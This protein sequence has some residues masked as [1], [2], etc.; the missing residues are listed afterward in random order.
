MKMHAPRNHSLLHGNRTVNT[1][2]VPGVKC[3]CVDPVTP[4]IQVEEEVEIEAFMYIVVVIVF[5]AT[6]I[7]FLLIKYARNDDEEK[8]LKY[9]YSEFVKRERFQAPQY[10]NKL[11]LERTKMCLE[12]IKCNGVPGYIERCPMITITTC[13]EGSES[14]SSGD[15]GL[16]ENG[17]D[18]DTDT[19][20]NDLDKDLA[21]ENPELSLRDQIDKGSLWEPASAD[22]GQS[23]SYD[24]GV[25]YLGGHGLDDIVVCDWTGFKDPVIVNDNG[26]YIKSHSI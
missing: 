24:S 5:Y 17:V 1:T 18:T 9:Q 22:S 4:R 7:V 16:K 21:N 15:S 10:K 3:V 11:A 25:D 6:S 12:N 23:L 26:V 19:I 14:T 13:S 2:A 8:N 20:I